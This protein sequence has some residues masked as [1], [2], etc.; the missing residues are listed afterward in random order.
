MMK[1]FYW[2]VRARFALLFAWIL[3]DETYL[4]WV[5]PARVGY[6]LNLKNPQTFNEKLQWLKLHDHNPNYTKMVDKVEAKKY[7]ANII[8]EEHIIPTLAV[9]DS[10]DEINFDELPRKFVLKCTH[11]SGGIVICKDKETLNKKDALEKLRKGLK[12][13]FYWENR[14]WPYKNV[15]PRIIAEQYMTDGD[16]ELKDYKVFNFGGEP[17]I[18][19]IDYNRFKG[20]LRT[21]YDTNWEKIN[22][23]IKFPTDQNRDFDKPK[24]LD[25]LLTLSKKLSMGIPHLRAD[26]YI[27]DNKIFF[28]ELTFFHGSG[29]EHI[30]PVAFDNQ[31]GDWIVLPI[32]NMEGGAIFSKKNIYVYIR[33]IERLEELKD[34][35][36]F[37]FNGEPKFMFIASDRFTPNTETKFDFFDMDF[38]HLPFLNG[39]PNA[40]VPILKPRNFEEMKKLASNLSKGIPHVRVDFYNIKG[41]IFFGEMTFFHWSGFVPFEPEEWDIKFGDMLKLYS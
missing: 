33:Q 35:K 12:K 38:N 25:E 18:I 14:E 40:S 26:F 3:P 10:V 4:K 1:L 19:E 5:F 13:N 39:H 23:V 29:M 6:P 22:A 30:T 7:V 27:V 8:G 9:Y 37:C 36:F 32:P 16:D 20:H 17:K 2:K 11:D 15:K 31:M 34:Y 41:K 24:V 21:L 28:G